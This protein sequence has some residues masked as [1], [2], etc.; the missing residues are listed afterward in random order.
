MVSNCQFESVVLLPQLSSIPRATTEE[1]SL[2]YD[3]VEA[4]DICASKTF[5][6]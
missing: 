4:A 3:T 1:G 5:L 2:V 6:R